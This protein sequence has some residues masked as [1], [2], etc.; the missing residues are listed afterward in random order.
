MVLALHRGAAMRSPALIV[1]AALAS[2][3]RVVVVHDPVPVMATADLDLDVAVDP[4]PPPDAAPAPPVDAA[5]A[6]AAF[7]R[8]PDEEYALAVRCDSDGDCALVTKTITIKRGRTGGTLIRFKPE[9]TGHA[10]ERVMM[11]V[12]WNPG[13][14]IAVW[15]DDTLAIKTAG[16]GRYSYERTTVPQAI[17]VMLA[18][19]SGDDHADH[20]VEVAV[21][22]GL[23]PDPPMIE[24]PIDETG[25][26]A[27]QKVPVLWDCGTDNYHC[28]ASVR[29]LAVTCPRQPATQVV[30]S[31][32]VP[33]SR[34]TATQFYFDLV[35][36]AGVRIA[37]YADGFAFADAER[38]GMLSLR[39]PAPSSL[40]LDL[41]GDNHRCVTYPLAIGFAESL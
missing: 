39:Q 37:V 17:D 28:T 4:E 7:V 20:E 34:A 30:L 9:V 18:P 32:P 36:P 16:R 23:E 22:A 31:P 38:A 26:L 15:D 10:P 3:T 29:T 40:V 6:P 33:P 41:Y 11:W 25:G 12:D 35:F 24:P 13:A 27:D 21:W 19:L 5:P 2:C 8:Q 14:A 1:V